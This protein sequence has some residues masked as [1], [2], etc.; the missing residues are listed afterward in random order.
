MTEKQKPVIV[1]DDNGQPRSS[2]YNDVYFTHLNGLEESRYVYLHLNNLAQ[3]FAE[4][5]E[6]A[7]FTVG[8]TGFGIGLNFLS[9]WHCFLHH[10]PASARL[11]Y[12]SVE[13]HPLSVQELEQALALTPELKDLATELVTHYPGQIE[14]FHRRNLA[15][16]RIHLTLI[17]D[18]VS[19]ALPKAL[20]TDHLHSAGV[21]AW[22]LDGFAPSR[23]P[24][25]WTTDVFKAISALSAPDATC[26]TFTVAQIVRNGLKEAGFSIERTQGFGQ[27]MEML[28]GRVHPSGEPHKRQSPDKPWLQ[29][30]TSPQPEN[31]TAIVIGAG[32]A[33]ASTAKALADKGWQVKVL[34][35]KATSADGASGNP[36][37]MLYTRLSTGDTSLTELVLQ[38]YRHTLHTLR[39]APDDVYQLSGLVQLP[40]SE[41][42]QQRQEKLAASDRFTHLLDSQTT[43]QLEENAG[44]KQEKEGLYFH[45]G[46]WVKPPAFVNWLL[47]H[48]NIHFTGN[49]QVTTM[50]RK[51][52]LWQLQL[53]NGE[54]HTSPVVVI[55]CGHQAHTLEQTIHL[56]LKAIRGQVTVVP[57]TQ[58]SEQLKTVLCEEGYIAPSMTDENGQ[59]CHTLGATFHFHDTDET[60]RPADHQANLNTI[61]GFTPAMADAL[62]FNQL[63]VNTLTGRT[64]F[65]CTTPDY[66]PVVG[67]VLNEVEFNEHFAVLKKNAKTKVQHPVPWHTGLYINAGH[68]SRGLITAPL[69]GE[70]LASQITGELSP[71][72]TRLTKELH[73]GRFPARALI[74]GSK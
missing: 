42:E 70:I 51:Q 38:G 7:V 55:A 35:Q 5:P 44:I 73:P 21:Q 25:I 39:Q 24:D 53:E 72:S 57:A 45:D 33:G 40:D 43:E 71:I 17:N 61:A 67:P 58:E 9:T 63:D 19:N 31:K 54:S 46:G 29:V 8:E 12:L 74:K 20:I 62:H 2:H 26:S 68:G 18:D 56:P 3:R 10:A 14:G 60:C 15:N 30:Q 50:S 49:S 48:P 22:F 52:N 28:R 6:N 23:N 59:S 13:K 64:G 69:A 1:W 16:G 11:H 4:L 32:M 27:K 65:R 47:D 34:D 41:K 37:G 36:Q 66:L